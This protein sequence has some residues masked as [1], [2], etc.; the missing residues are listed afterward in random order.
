M[1]KHEYYI[2]GRSKRPGEVLLG[3][4]G[5]TELFQAREYQDSEG[6]KK[7]GAPYQTAK[8]KPDSKKMIALRLYEWQKKRIKA[9]KTTA[10][11][12]LD[13]AV[14]ALPDV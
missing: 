4:R 6:K 5:C 7:L 2:R 3:C 13:E 12:L 8:R 14:D 10:Q 9:N 1:H 11:K